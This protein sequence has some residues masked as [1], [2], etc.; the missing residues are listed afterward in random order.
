MIYMAAMCI[1]TCV[2]MNMYIDVN[3]HMYKLYILTQSVPC[4]G[5]ST[6]PC[7]LQN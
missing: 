3:V 6:E 7:N 5:I 4:L 1:H 2:H